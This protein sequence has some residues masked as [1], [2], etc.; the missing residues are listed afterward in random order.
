MQGERKTAARTATTRKEE[1]L[2]RQPLPLVHYGV[3]DVAARIPRH[4]NSD[5]L[6]SAGMLG[7]LHAART[8]DPSRSVRSALFPGAQILL[9]LIAE[10]GRRDGPSRSV[11]TR[12]K[13][14]QAATAEL[15][16]RL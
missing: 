16:G 4:V 3:A 9:E 5:D 14:L 1:Q 13:E 6:V 7:L 8:F 10:L 11:R 12:S 15:T 2:V